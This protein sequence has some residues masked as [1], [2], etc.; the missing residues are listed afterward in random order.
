MCTG[1][2]EDRTAASSI[3]SRHILV[4]AATRHC[5]RRTST[6][7]WR[8]AC[9]PRTTPTGLCKTPDLQSRRHGVSHRHLLGSRLRCGYRLE[10]DQRVE[11]HRR[12]R[13]KIKRSA[14]FS[15]AET[16]QPGAASGVK[17]Y[18]HERHE[19]HEIRMQ[20]KNG[21]PGE[22]KVRPDSRRS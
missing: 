1:A 8:G 18:T 7:A 16:L 17:L 6:R 21:P 10:T 9:S 15:K 2:T 22:F 20:E 4:V 3:R 5:R 11:A 19:R 12:A 14:A 13:Q